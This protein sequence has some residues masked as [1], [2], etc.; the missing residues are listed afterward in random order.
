MAK[1]GL[2]EFEVQA[3]NKTKDMVLQLMA[4]ILHQLIG[5]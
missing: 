1:D 5:R 2:N 3:S 4:E